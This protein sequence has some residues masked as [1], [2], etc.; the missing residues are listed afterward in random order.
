M[1]FITIRNDKNGQIKRISQYAW[2]LRR[3]GRDDGDSRRGWTKVS[4]P[5][6][7]PESGPVT[8]GP[9][10]TFLPEEIREA[11]E[12]AHAA[13]IKRDSA[14]ISAESTSTS[15]GA[16]MPPST[17]SAPAAE[18]AG[19]PVAETTTPPKEPAAEPVAAE[20]TAKPDDLMKLQAGMSPKVV[21]LLAALGV[22]TFRQMA[23]MPV[24][25]IHKMLDDGGLGPKKA[26]ATGW[27]MKA[28]QL[29]K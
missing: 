6:P 29:T 13:Q 4:G 8:G 25:D 9:Q 26:M 21:E 14:M 28:G 27:K 24:A 18:A 7:P 10:P 2:D 20:V 12:K 11:A 22:V 23:D 3:N 5:I 19:A 17:P 16:E 1:E 15:N